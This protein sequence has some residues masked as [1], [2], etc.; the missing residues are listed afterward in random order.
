MSVIDTLSDCEAQLA[1]E[2]TQLLVGQII[3]C[4]TRMH[5]WM[6]HSPDVY[7]VDVSMTVQPCDMLVPGRAPHT[8][9]AIHNG[10]DITNGATTQTRV[11]LQEYSIGEFV[12]VAQY[13]VFKNAVTHIDC[14]RQV[15]QRKKLRPKPVPARYAARSCGTKIKHA[16]TQLDVRTLWLWLWYMRERSLALL[17]L[18]PDHKRPTAR[19]ILDD[20]LSVANY[21]DF[22]NFMPIPQTCHT[23][24]LFLHALFREHAS[25]IEFHTMLS[26][27]ANSP[28]RSLAFYAAVDQLK[29]VL[30][31]VL[32]PPLNAYGATPSLYCTTTTSTVTVTQRDEPATEI[33]MDFADDPELE[34]ANVELGEQL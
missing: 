22:T 24:A 31:I 1:L 11:S 4:L 15:L 12:G 30:A 19:A 26:E 10:A 7:R 23:I 6:T 27:F 5:K 21:V 28:E 13:R 16:S 9:V 3:R 34:L 20:F 8:I 32:L 18:G 29:R 25:G 33:L 14:A 17:P 2:I